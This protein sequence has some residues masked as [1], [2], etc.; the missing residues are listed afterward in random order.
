MCDGWV[1]KV[2]KMTNDAMVNHNTTN[3]TQI[4]ERVEPE[5][6]KIIP[7]ATRDAITD[8]IKQFLLE[9][10]DTEQ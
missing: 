4:L 8:Q 2:K 7:I 6:L 3:F 9:I 10:V 5:A 1:D